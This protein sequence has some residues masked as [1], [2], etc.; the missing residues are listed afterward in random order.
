MQLLINIPNAFFVPA[1]YSENP[2]EQEVNM[3]DEGVIDL[4]DFNMDPEEEE[5]IRCD[6]LDVS[7]TLGTF[8]YGIFIDWFQTRRVKTF[9]PKT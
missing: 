5:K 8:M 9:Q 2:A 4:M 1:M 6:W 7:K 3:A